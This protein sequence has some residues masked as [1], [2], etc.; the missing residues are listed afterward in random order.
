MKKDG[1]TDI[2]SL[3]GSG[4]YWYPNAGKQARRVFDGS[5]TL[6][7][8]DPGNNPSDI[9]LADVDGDGALDI[10]S[11][12][13]Y[14]ISWYRNT[15]GTGNFSSQINFGGLQ[16]HVKSLAVADFDGDGW[17]DIAAASAFQDNPITWYKNTCSGP[18]LMRESR[19]D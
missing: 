2:A 8:Q 9:L 4:I 17:P 11:A 7:T 6:V 14:K 1:S 13:A 18:A 10:I 5:A 19:N 15:D 12:S 16:N 3:T